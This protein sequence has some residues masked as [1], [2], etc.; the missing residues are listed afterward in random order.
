MKFSGKNISK[1]EL[2]YYSNCKFWFPLCIIIEFVYLGWRC[3][4]PGTLH[5]SVIEKT[6][7]WIFPTEMIILVR[8]LFESDLR[9]S[10]DAISQM[11]HLFI[12]YKCLHGSCSWCSY[13]LVSNIDFIILY[14][15]KKYLFIELKG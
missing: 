8:I 13:V 3:F 5:W 11:Y 9:I 7:K 15:N 10:K 2:K 14:C 12:F 1:N 4:L 6:F